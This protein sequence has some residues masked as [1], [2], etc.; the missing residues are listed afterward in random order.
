MML[1]IGV[2]ICANEIDKSILDLLKKEGCSSI[3][4]SFWKSLDKDKYFEVAK[5]L[6]SYDFNVSAVSIFGNTIESDEIKDAWKFLI[7][8]NKAMGNPYITGF[9][10]RVNTK[11]VEDSIMPW[12][13][14]F[15]E[16]LDLSYKHDCKGL[17]LENCRMGDTW[18]R[19]KWNI[20]INPSAWSLM[21]DA[22]DDEKL[23]LEWEPYH[24]ILALI[25]PIK[26]LK[27]WAK[28]VKHVHGKDA[29]TDWAKLR[30][31]G[32]YDKEKAIVDEIPLFGD[33]DW[34]D[35]ITVLKENNYKG[36]IDIETQNATFLSKKDKIL[37]SLHYL[38]NINSQVF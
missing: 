36:S 38:N 15:T 31:I 23:G 33:T 9:A 2:V 13:A 18:K 10:G 27:T 17:L 12:K 28:K 25:D 26:Q 6:E 29:K 11:S 20:A 32:L 35:V 34:K 22:L 16:L 1:Q 7:K 30:R 37:K 5:L 3:S 14:I 21:F 24:Q 19:G 4:V 8:E